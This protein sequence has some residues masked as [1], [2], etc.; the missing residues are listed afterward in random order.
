MDI[1][2]R[3]TRA[4]GLY[5]FA[6]KRTKWTWPE[7]NHGGTPTEKEVDISA[8][9]F[10]KHV[11]ID[12]LQVTGYW[13]ERDSASYEKMTPREVKMVNKHIDT[14]L[15]RIHKIIKPKK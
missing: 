3:M 4:L 8:R 1:R 5:E 14:F 12:S 11:I 10:A 9:E 15:S 2:E 7:P 6:I 13:T